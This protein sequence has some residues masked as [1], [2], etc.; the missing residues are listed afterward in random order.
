[1]LGRTDRSRQRGDAAQ[2]GLAAVLVDD[3]EVVLEGLHRA[4]V[5]DGIDV[6]AGFLDA[7]GALA[8]LDG[9]SPSAARVELAV[10]DLRLGGG[11]GLALAEQVMR[12]RPDVRVAIL[13]SFEDHAAAVAAVRSGVRGFFIKDSSCSELGAGLRRV[14]AGELVIDSRLAEA[15]FTGRADHLTGHETAILRLVAAGLSNRRIGEQLHLSPYTVKE[16]LSRVMRK[17]GTAS[18]TETALRADRLGL[19]PQDPP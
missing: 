12:V 7:A 5:R 4:L 11:S 18:R 2:G 3:H 16:Y 14:A 10:V 6:V 8:F 1:M 9:G 13:T 15:V 17:L 19:L